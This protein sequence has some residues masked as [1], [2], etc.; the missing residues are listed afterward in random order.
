VAIGSGGFWGKGWL[1]GTSTKNQFVPEQHTDFIFCAVGEQFGFVGSAILII[2]YVSLMLR[3]IVL[4][5]SDNDQCLLGFMLIRWPGSC[6]SILRSI[7][8]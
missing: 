7:Y 1:N 5:A 6:F 3:I 2:L 4:W 8:L